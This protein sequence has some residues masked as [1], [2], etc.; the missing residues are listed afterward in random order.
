[1]RPVDRRSGRIRL[2]EFDG[3]DVDALH[4]VYGDVEATRYLSFEPR[5]RHDVELLVKRI[6]ADS[7]ADPRTEY[8]LAV[9]EL[10]SGDVIGMA[11]LALGEWQSGQVG[12][13]LRPDRWRLGLG[14][15]AV[16]A[17]LDLGFGE[18]GLHR[19]WGAR[20]PVN[21]ASARLMT[22][23]GMV[24]EGRVRHHVFVRGGWRDS[25]VHSVL[26]S[27]WRRGSP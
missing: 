26:E 5:S 17:L 22:R 3:G 6:V 12:F 2:R 25:V 19:I 23:I 11:R 13:A 18:L 14:T 4:R 24:E 9:E 21:Q 27:E 20:S 10:E 7:H 1:M 15:E 16:Q 8:A